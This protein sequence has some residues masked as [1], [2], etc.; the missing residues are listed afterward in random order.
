MKNLEELCDVAKAFSMITVPGGNRLVVIT[1]SGGAGILSSDA[2]EDAG[3]VLS[4]FSDSTLKRLR[5]DLPDYCVIGNPL[6]LTGN[7]L[8]NAHLYGDALDVVLADDSVDMVLVV[9]GDPIPNSFEAIEKQVEK[10]RSLG[11]PVAV[12]YLGGGEVQEIETV[13][14]QKNGLPVF[15]TPSRAVV[16]LSYMHRYG[17]YVSETEG[18]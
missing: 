9:Y 16:A 13:S 10:A 17:E 7:A 11:I 15:E 18:A 3:L 8:N 4:N 5:E 6:D 1:S 2:C 14:L 12:N